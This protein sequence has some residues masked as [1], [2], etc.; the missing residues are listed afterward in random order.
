MKYDSREAIVQTPFFTGA[1]TRLFYI[2]QFIP[3][4]KTRACYSIRNVY[5]PW[6]HTV[7]K[8]PKL[9][10]GYS[11]KDTPSTDS[12]HYAKSQGHKHTARYLA[13]TRLLS[14]VL[15]PMNAHV[16]QRFQFHGKKSAHQNFINSASCPF[17]GYI[18]MTDEQGTAQRW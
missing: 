5:V 4:S 3:V 18:R 2:L 14:G 12:D 9:S 10:Q 16:A 6:T 1:T 11:D 17:E 15:Y 8:G 7:D 13:R